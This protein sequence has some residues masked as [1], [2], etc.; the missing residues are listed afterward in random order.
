[1]KSIILVRLNP[2]IRSLP[3][4]GQANCQSGDE[5]CLSWTLL[6]TA[7]SFS[8]D[9]RIAFVGTDEEAA[10]HLDSVTESITR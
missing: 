10:N 3:L 9:D 1:M 6:R 8:S 7:V 5:K 4:K 2:R